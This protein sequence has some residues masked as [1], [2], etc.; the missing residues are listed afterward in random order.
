MPLDDEQLTE[1][2]G[3]LVEVPGVVAVLLGGS[4]ARGDHLAESDFDLGLYYRPHLHQ[5]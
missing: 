2:A 5:E 1:L 4:R 3:R